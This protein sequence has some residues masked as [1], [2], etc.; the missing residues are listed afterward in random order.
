MF[1]ALKESVNGGQSNNN[2]IP[3][4]VSYDMGWSK[5]STGRVYDSLS[6]HGFLV[7]CHT[8]KIIHMRVLCKNVAFV[9][10]IVAQ[11]I[12]P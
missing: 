10:H 8:G 3:L 5:R 12:E 1:L 4:T 9:V 6:G 7:G 11:K 2:V